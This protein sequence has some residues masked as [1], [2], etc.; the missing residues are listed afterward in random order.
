M[1]IIE[2]LRPVLAQ[3]RQRYYTWRLARMHRQTIAEQ[4][5]GPNPGL[6][7]ATQK[8]ALAFLTSLVRGYR[9]LRWHEMLVRATGR[10]S[11]YYLP[12]DI[13][14][15]LVLPHL[16][17]P[18]RTAILADKNHFDRIEG[19]PPLPVTIGRLMNGRLLDPHYR[20]AT[21]ADL[22]RQL[23]STTELIIKPTRVSGSSKD[24]A[25]F[26]AA[27]LAD[28]LPG[29]TDA[30][31]QLPVAQHRDLAVLNAGSVNTLRITTY[32]KLTGEVLHLGS[33]LR[34]GR[35]QRRVNA[36][37][38]FCGVDIDRGALRAD[39]YKN[40]PLTRLEAHPDNGLLFA[41]RK[42]PG[43][44]AACDAMVAAHAQTPWIDLASWDVAIDTAGRPVTIE[45]NVGTSAR[46]QQIA[47]GPIF[48]P[49]ADD[50]RARIGNRRYSRVL[51]FL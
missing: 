32:R 14:Y 36:G 13:L 46:I 16:N 17:P 48:E 6:D 38:I 51:G 34:V 24:V 2:R 15:A 18:G 20:P 23:T 47:C 9:D 4:P 28:M 19:W 35:A 43:F 49:V 25:F 26:E 21:A 1:A 50:L 7:A 30:I 10:V 11:P 33:F 29:R 22:V 5:P 12:D 39:A 27:K 44:A 41:A 42:I 3:G 45:V 40:D 31:I 37:G 8:E